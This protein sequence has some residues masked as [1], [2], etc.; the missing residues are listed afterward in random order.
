MSVEFFFFEDGVHSQ[1]TL[2]SKE[3]VDTEWL[4]KCGRYCIRIWVKNPQNPI[5][6]GCELPTKHGYCPD[7]THVTKPCTNKT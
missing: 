3:E 7:N 6:V 2:T 4:A 5:N 1:I